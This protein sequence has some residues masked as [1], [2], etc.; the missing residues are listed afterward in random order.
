MTQSLKTF[1]FD[2]AKQVL[3]ELPLISSSDLSNNLDY[4][5]SN[6][7]KSNNSYLTTT[8]GTGRNP[9]SILLSNESFGTE[10]AHSRAKV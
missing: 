9:T 8:G 7:F 2:E 6:E 3:A 4:F 10:W 1:F 5:I